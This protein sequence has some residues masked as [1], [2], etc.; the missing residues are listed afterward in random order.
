[1]PPRGQEPGVEILEVPHQGIPCMMGTFAADISAVGAEL[2]RSKMTGYIVPFFTKIARAMKLQSNSC[3][4]IF[5]GCYFARHDLSWFYHGIRT[6]IG[7]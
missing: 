3:V 6:F 5:Q 4:A 7:F 2:F 1:M